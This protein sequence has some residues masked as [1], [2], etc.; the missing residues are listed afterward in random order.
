MILGLSTSFE[1]CA[2][3]MTL[4]F[5][6][7]R[8]FKPAMKVDFSFFSQGQFK[9]SIEVS[10]SNGQEGFTHPCDCL[11]CDSVSCIAYNLGGSNVF[12]QRSNTLMGKLFNQNIPRGSR[13]LTFTLSEGTTDIRFSAQ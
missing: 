12:H 8:D 3:Q 13:T 2:S 1:V 11:E 10:C 9:K 5:N 6:N 7:Q 4:E